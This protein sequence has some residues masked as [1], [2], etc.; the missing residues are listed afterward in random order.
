MDTTEKTAKTAGRKSAVL[1]LEEIR[2]MVYPISAGS[3]PKLINY[4]AVRLYISISYT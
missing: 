4:K 1:G 3:K 2:Q